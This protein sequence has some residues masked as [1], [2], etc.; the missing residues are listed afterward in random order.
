MKL[1][2]TTAQQDVINKHMF[3]LCNFYRLNNRK[4]RLARG[5][6]DGR[7]VSETDNREKQVGPVMLPSCNSISSRADSA[8]VVSTMNGCQPS[9][10]GDAELRGDSDE[11]MGMLVA[12][13]SRTT[14]G[15]SINYEPGQFV[16]ILDKEAKEIGTGKVYQVRGSWYGKELMQSG[17]CVVDIMELR[18]DR[19]TELPHPSEFTGQSFD[20][21]EKRLGLMRVLWDTKQLAVLPSR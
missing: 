5:A 21:A 16:L 15:Q 2:L 8:N 11:N 10:I 17:T 12:T 4:A 1:I 20:Q 9:E 6:K 14:L 3:F 13:F 18:T 19:L 7:S